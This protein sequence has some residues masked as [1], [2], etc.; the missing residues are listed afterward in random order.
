MKLV[1]K[2][3]RRFMSRQD[4]LYKLLS[5]KDNKKLDEVSVKYAELSVTG[6]EGGTFYFRYQGRKLEPL[7]GIPDVPPRMLDRFKLR[8]DGLNYK[9]GDEV[10][11]DVVAGSL[12][13]RDALSKHYFI[14]D[15]DH[16]LYDSEEF[17]Q[18]FETFLAEMRKVLTGRNLR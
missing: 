8:G 16:M 12:T 14:S 18:S 4:L 7:D 1:E 17:A 6:P 15:T 10:F 2:M 5:P 13:P 11:F 3:L 9:G